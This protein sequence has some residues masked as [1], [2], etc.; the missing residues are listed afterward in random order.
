MVT[1]DRK[2]KPVLARVVD[3]AGIYRSLPISRGNAF[4][5]ASL[6]LATKFVNGWVTST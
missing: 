5:V 3:R 4:R 6:L 2:C 1:K